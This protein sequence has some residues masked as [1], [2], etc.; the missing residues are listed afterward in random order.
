M[1]KYLPALVLIF[2][3]FFAGVSRAMIDSYVFKVI[4]KVISISADKNTMRL[5]I[6]SVV[7]TEKDSDTWAGRHY[8]MRA[9]EIN[10]ANY[11]KGV[12]TEEI[13]AGSMLVGDFMGIETEV[14]G[15]G[16]RTHYTLE[17]KEVIPDKDA[18]SYFKRHLKQ[19]EQLLDSDNNIARINVAAIGQEF[20]LK[21]L[22]PA[23]EETAAT[24]T[25]TVSTTTTT[26]Y[27]K[28]GSL[29]GVGLG[30]SRSRA[31][32]FLGRGQYIG[33]SGKM[34]FYS[35]DKG[36]KLIGF[37]AILDQ[38]AYM[39]LTSDTSYNVEN[40]SVND[41]SDHVS[42]ILGAAESSQASGESVYW[43]Y[44]S[45]NI[46]VQISKKEGKVRMIGVYDSAKFE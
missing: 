12:P 25:T 30:M 37:R 46:V 15:K 17:V 35:Y 2:I 38:G 18:K 29:F 11:A 32:D 22:V 4:G 7:P 39:I 21:S 28:A 20:D 23:K 16:Y 14:H 33:E 9:V 6:L 8:L 13:K 43:Y 34:N 31:D 42:K 40:I 36:A 19:L 24:T 26:L 41:S 3:L 45:R 1:K 5:D 27:P 10:M 44:P